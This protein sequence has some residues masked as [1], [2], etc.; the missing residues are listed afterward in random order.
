MPLPELARLESEALHDFAPVLAPPEA[1]GLL[2]LDKSFEREWL[3]VNP[4][5][6]RRERSVRDVLES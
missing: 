1:C 5:S 2:P 4:G 6:R 3:V